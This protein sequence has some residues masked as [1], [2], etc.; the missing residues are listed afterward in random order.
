[1]PSAAHLRI[2]G[3]TRPADEQTNYRT[4]GQTTIDIS[5]SIVEN[6]IIR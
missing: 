5:I 2:F 4:I 1:M 3:P 6:F